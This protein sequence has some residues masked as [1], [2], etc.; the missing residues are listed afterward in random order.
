MI[1]SYALTDSCLIDTT[2]AGSLSK[3]KFPSSIT[4]CCRSS[5]CLLSMIFLVASRMRR[6]PRVCTVRENVHAIFVF[7]QDR[8]GCPPS[9]LT[10][11]IWHPSHAR[12]V[13]VIR[14]LGDDIMW[15]FETCWPSMTVWSYS[16][17]LLELYALYCKKF[18]KFLRTENNNEEGIAREEEQQ[19]VATLP[20]SMSPLLMVI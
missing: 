11:R 19:P 4:D 9:H 14:L 20:H 17:Q 18:K 12:F 3:P 16:S 7:A 5:R 6:G 1:P 8:Q 13:R 15:A 10:L 2:S